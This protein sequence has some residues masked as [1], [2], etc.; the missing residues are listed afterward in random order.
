MNSKELKPIPLLK[1]GNNGNLYRNITLRLNNVNET[2][3][4]E[5][6]EECTDKLHN[7]TFSKLPY[8][9]CKNN[10]IMY[11]FNDQ[12]YPSALSPLISGG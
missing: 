5:F 4:W 7:E 6:S 9:D 10:N 11:T 2:L 3:W 1:L 8:S 12:S